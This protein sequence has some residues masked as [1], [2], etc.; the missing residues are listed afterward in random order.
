MA[1][2]KLN[3]SS[4]SSNNA[5][6]KKK[7]NI[8]PCRKPRVSWSLHRVLTPL[9]ASC[10]R[11]WRVNREAGGASPVV[12]RAVSRFLAPLAEG[13]A[14]GPWSCAVPGVASLGACS[15]WRLAWGF[16]AAAGWGEGAARLRRPS[17]CSSCRRGHRPR[18]L[19]R[20]LV[21]RPSRRAQG[22]RES[23]LLAAALCGGLGGEVGLGVRD[24]VRGGTKIV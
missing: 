12:L 18:S 23:P 2:Q 21:R 5:A 22:A 13:P 16:L 24:R 10:A 7:M 9:P 19:H 6:V 14:P 17:R 1:H 15:W 8:S 3:V 11:C 4:C 20:G